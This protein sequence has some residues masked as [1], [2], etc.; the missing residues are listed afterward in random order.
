MY[1]FCA[2]LVFRATFVPVTEVCL[3]VQS[4]Y[5]DGYVSIHPTHSCGPVTLR[6]HSLFLLQVLSGT[7]VLCWDN[8]HDLVPELPEQGAL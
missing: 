8:A 2:G 7:R 5:I 4:F 1:V 3:S 6:D